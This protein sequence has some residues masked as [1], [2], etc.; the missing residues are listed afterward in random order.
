[1]GSHPSCSTSPFALEG[2]LRSFGVWCDT[3][4]QLNR[5]QSGVT[6]R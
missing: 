2:R 5:V 4:D 1:M 3:R 6:Y